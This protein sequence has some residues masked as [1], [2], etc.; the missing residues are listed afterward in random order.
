[1]LTSEETIVRIVHEFDL[2]GRSL[3]ERDMHSIAQGLHYFCQFAQILRGSGDYFDSG[4]FELEQWHNRDFSY[5]PGLRASPFS[6]S[7]HEALDSLVQR[8][9][10]RRDTSSPPRY[11]EPR[12]KQLVLFP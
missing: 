5:R 1:V 7:L 2:V 4:D 3:N 10:V 8:G 9:V 12:V 11:S 6:R